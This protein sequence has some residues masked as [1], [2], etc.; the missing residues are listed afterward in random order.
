MSELSEETAGALRSALGAEH[1]ALWVHGLASAFVEEARVRSALDEAAGEHEELRGAAEQ[2]LRDAQLTPPA[3]EPAYSPPS[4]VTDQR[5][6]I[7]VLITAE[8]DCQIGWR[9]VLENAENAELRRT[10]LNGLTTAATRETR[11][12]LTIGEQPAVSAFPG[13]P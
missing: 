8:N 5:S 10:A 1:A 13:K 12:R 3:A 6:A 4:H 7:A 9:S 2:V 11:W